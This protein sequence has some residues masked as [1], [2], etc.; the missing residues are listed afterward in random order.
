[1]LWAFLLERRRL[2]IGRYIIGLY[3]KKYKGGTIFDYRAQPLSGSFNNIVELR[4]HIDEQEKPNDA[5]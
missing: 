1:M 5:N 4:K 2:G 3:T